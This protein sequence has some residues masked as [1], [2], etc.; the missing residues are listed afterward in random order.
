[1]S[2]TLKQIS[3]LLLGH[4]RRV[5]LIG[6]A[7][8]GM[9][10]LAG[11][12]LE[13][14]HQVS[15]SDRVSTVETRRLEQAGLKFYLPQTAE[16]VRESDLVI[17]SSAI[18]PGNAAHD[19]ARRLGLPMF[20]RAEALAAIMAA[21]KGVVVAGMHGK[22]TTS[23][24]AAHVLRVGGAKP[25][26]YV[27]AE[28]PLL[29]ANSHWDAEG[30][31]FVAEGDESDGT[32]RNYQ[33]EHSIIL[34]IEEEHLD[35]YA[36]LAGIEAVFTQLIA[37]TRNTIFYCAD[38]P[39]TARLCA[40]I[41]NAVSFGCSGRADYQY[42]AV[43]ARADGSEF[44]VF[45]KTGEIFGQ[46]RLGVPGLHNVTN[47]LAVVALADA[48]GI[49]VEKIAEGLK[50]FR[51]AR[52]RFEIRH[53]S[54]D[55][56]VVDD[57]GHHPTEIKATLSTA[58]ALGCARVVVMFQPHR[59]SRTQALR[60]QFGTAFS[61]GDLIYVTEIYAA[62]EAPIPG[63]TGESLAAAIQATKHS[64]VI[65][66]PERELLH[67]EIA[68]V[69]R[70]GDLL[71]SLGA[72]D[73][74]EEAAKLVSDL[75]HAAGLRESMGAGELRLYEPLAKHTTLRVGGP[76]QFWLEPET[77]GGLANLLEYCSANRV[78][79]FFV[80]R[81]SN[82]LV[83]DGGIPGVVIHLNRGQFVDVTVE[84][85]KIRAGAGLRL[86]Q[87]AALAKSAGL[88]GFEWMEGIP[89]SVGGSLRMNAGAMK[90][91]TFSQVV[92]V[93][94]VNTRGEF[95]TLTPAEMVVRY[96]N[97]PTL[98][99]RF[100]VAATFRGIPAK[101]TEIER[102]LAASFAHRKAT[103]PI[104]ASAGCI[105]KNPPECPA[106]KLVEELG[107]KNL[108]VGSA[109]VSEV[110]GNFIVNDGGATSRDILQLIAQIQDRAKQ[111]CGITL[112]TEVQIVGTDQ[113]V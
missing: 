67:S 15:G 3:T 7:G 68:R 4:S 113:V 55:F 88:G 61:Q 83:R 66:V 14:G 110:H 54:A 11:L 33:P 64:G 85:D 63:V 25:S 13:L 102:L 17:F 62:G 84:G 104:A 105:F 16:S 50:T 36:D 40:L 95:K 20:R 108:A 99:D 38:D 1:M 71:I 106:G 78:P 8:S 59:Y 107:L 86:K 76:A 19:E 94:V 89:G 2:D 27:G 42:R 18:K 96:R 69:A 6:V 53:Q 77:R 24:L 56:I 93:Q 30:A 29:G 57:Y 103:Q 44:A 34:N 37:Q 48:L 80:G 72:G 12:L 41:P 28:I 32:L 31:F 97:V 100:A 70:P 51:G 22:T 45:R 75:K 92:E 43:I 98:Q 49:S 5:H 26:H 73:V 91:E 65:Y 46:F 81:G 90:Q 109:R 87:L 23:A 82:L 74:H 47:A 79:F 35:Y 111:V 58:R 21:K 9:S 101:I 10:G 112:E 39:N 52:R 60:N